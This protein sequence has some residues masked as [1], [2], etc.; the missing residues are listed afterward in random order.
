MQSRRER[1]SGN[2]LAKLADFQEEF[3]INY[4]CA[5]ARL[6]THF[7]IPWEIDSSYGVDGCCNGTGMCGIIRGETGVEEG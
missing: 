4:E 7:E 1:R 6:P 5:F 3:G 2:S